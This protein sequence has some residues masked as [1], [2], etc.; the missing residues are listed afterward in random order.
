MQKKVFNNKN[1]DRKKAEIRL[2]HIL[3]FFSILHRIFL[4]F[5]YYIFTEKNEDYHLK[6]G[7]YPENIKFDILRLN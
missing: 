6:N 1:G 2:R 5:S 4:Y 7:S 3:N